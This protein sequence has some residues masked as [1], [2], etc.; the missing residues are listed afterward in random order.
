MAQLSPQ[1]LAAKWQAAVAGASAAY[2]AGVNAV[3]VN[4]AQSAIAAVDRWVAG[5]QA[6]AANGSYVKGLQNVT[7]QSW[8]QAAVTK[9]APAL[10]TGAQV[11]QAKVMAAAT[12]WQPIVQ[13]L[14][15]SLPPRGTVE[16]NINRAATFIRGMASAKAN[17]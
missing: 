2:T 1:A 14:V 9:G 17:S 10:A 4:P 15:A 5:I 13:Q 16:Q 12:K 3:S 11:G 7:L 6:A 8:K